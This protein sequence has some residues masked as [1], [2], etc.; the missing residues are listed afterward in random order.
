MLSN[1]ISKNTNSSNTLSINKI[2]QISPYHN[3]Q[4]LLPINSRKF[5]RI[6][7]KKNCSFVFYVLIFVLYTCSL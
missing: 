7:N 2:C 6:N 5:E 4:N 3:F 1:F